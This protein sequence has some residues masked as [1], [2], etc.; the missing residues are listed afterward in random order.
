[1]AKTPPKGNKVQQTRH[2]PFCDEEIYD[3]NL[4]IC[5]ACHTTIVYCTQCHEPLPKSQTTCPKCGTKTK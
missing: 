5:S 1:M 4:P 2:C 3:L